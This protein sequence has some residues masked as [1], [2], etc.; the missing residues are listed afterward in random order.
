LSGAVSK[1][2]GLPVRNKLSQVNRNA[3]VEGFPFKL[4]EKAL[5][6]KLRSEKSRFSKKAGRKRQ[7]TFFIFV[8]LYTIYRAGS[9]NH[10]SIKNTINN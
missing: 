8:Q 10:G 5:N 1:Q 9:R 7:A 3:A 4:K 6:W 2:S